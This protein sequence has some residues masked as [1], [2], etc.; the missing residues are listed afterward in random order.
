MNR[1]EE[2]LSL[3]FVSMLTTRDVTR[4]Y[5][6]VRN[7][8][9]KENGNKK[10]WISQPNTGDIRRC[11]NLNVCLH[12][13]GQQPKLGII[14]RQKSRRLRAMESIM[15]QSCRS[16]LQPN[17][18]ADTDFCLD[19]YKKTWQPAVQEIK[20]LLLFHKNLEAHSQES[21]RNFSTD[22][23]VIPWFGVPAATDIW[24]LVDGGYISTLKMFINHKFSDWLDDSENLEKLDGAYSH[25]TTNKKRIL[26][27]N[28]A[29]NTYHKLKQSSS[30]SF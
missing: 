30:D 11:F 21:F 19:W 6:E 22:L 23:G 12:P 15:G 29:V 13:S 20:G 18:L 3:I 8:S 26:I 24:Q 14:F 9:T 4:S 5:R 28:W 7:G 1:N 16:L 17:M 2:D 27:T 25:I 10:T